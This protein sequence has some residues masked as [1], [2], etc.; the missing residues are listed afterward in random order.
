MALVNLETYYSF[1]NIS[2]KNNL[3]KYSPDKGVN[4][5]DIY[6][7]EGCYE[8][9][10]LNETIHY[11]MKQKKHYNS[12]ND[13]YFI[14]IAPN[15]STLRTIMTLENN[16]QVDF[17]PE[18]SLSNTL[19]FERKIYT[20]GLN[21]S[22]SVVN[23]LNINSILVNVDIIEGSYVN[24]SQQPTLYS[25]FPN[26]SPGFKIVETP[27]NLVYLPIFMNTI[28]RM[29]TTITD[30]NGTLLNNRGEVITIRFHIKEM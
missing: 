19:G 5:V 26:V 27:K 7:P 2:S 3:F 13:A 23:I 15:T 21:E 6:I 20:S 1:P 24:G 14:S 22:E 12:V 11:M 30:Q 4:W 10:D 8:L 16:F 18:N 28:Q 17:R 29:E 25:F 9:K